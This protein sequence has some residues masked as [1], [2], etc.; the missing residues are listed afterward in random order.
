M[1]KVLGLLGS[2]VVRY[3][4]VLK[5]KELIFIVKGLFVL[6]IVWLKLILFIVIVV[7]ILMLIVVII[8]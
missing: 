3:L 1:I 5:M 6:V 4:V 2:R 8:K 7:V